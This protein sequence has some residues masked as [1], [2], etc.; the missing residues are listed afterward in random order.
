MAYY[1]VDVTDFDDVDSFTLMVRSILTEIKKDLDHIT[2]NKLMHLSP[3]LEKLLRN[4]YNR[5]K[6]SSR[7][8]SKKKL[9]K[10]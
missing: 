4:L 3:V 6:E 1:I 5:V 9:N 2:K 8:K 7:G 10:L